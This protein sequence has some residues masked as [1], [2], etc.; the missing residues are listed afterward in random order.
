[1]DTRNTTL[2]ACLAAVALA[3]A[4][5][6]LSLDRAELKQ[7]IASL[8]A[9]LAAARV[10]APAVPPASDDIGETKTPGAQA[11]AQPAL[12]APAASEE[13]AI[14]TQALFDALLENAGGGEGNPVGNAMTESLRGLLDGGGDFARHAAEM[15]VDMMYGPFINDFDISA[16]LREQLRDALVESASGAMDGMS[17]SLGAGGWEEMAAAGEALRGDLLA[18]VGEILGP[19]G[20]AAF[21]TYEQELPRRMMEQSIDMQLQF[22]GIGMAEDTRTLLRDALVD[23][24][25]A[26]MPAPGDDVDAISD[27]MFEDQG[28][29]YARVM[30]QFREILSAED[31]IGVE[32]FL[33]QQIDMHESMRNMM[34]GPD[35]AL[36]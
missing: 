18:R 3:A 30:E 32:R 7:T 12:E 8:E 29:A 21:E 35:A 33:R 2:A 15:S 9:E 36:P 5:G 10:A 23:E 17:A 1:M 6:Y 14:N 31:F 27:A 28:A 26:V 13:E 11:F 20:L 24:L 34:V 25:V 19:E 16:E 22:M 4:V